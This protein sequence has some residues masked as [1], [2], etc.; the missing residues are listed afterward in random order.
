MYIYLAIG[1]SANFSEYRC[2][3]FNGPKGY[4]INS[5]ESAVPLLRTLFRRSKKNGKNCVSIF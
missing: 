4:A 1:K 2:A 3:K 5:I